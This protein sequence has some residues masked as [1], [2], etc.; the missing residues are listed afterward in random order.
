MGV[1]LSIIV[2]ATTSLAIIGTAGR[3]EDAARL[4]GN[5]EM[6]VDR[7]LA[8]ARKVA[9]L[10]KASHLVSGG[11]AWA[12]H[13]AVLLFLADPARFTLQI[14]APAPMV[15]SHDG[16]LE[17]RDTGERGK[18]SFI[19]NPGGTC[20]HYHRQF[21]D[22]LGAT[23]PNWSPFLDFALIAGHPRVTVRVTHGFDARN[24]LVA[25]ADNALAMTFGAGATL[26]DGGTTRTMRSFLR[27]DGRGAAYHLDLSAMK[28]H[29]NA[30]VVGS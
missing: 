22:A 26:K 12:D 24:E 11:A 21:L 9:D 4:A 8:A 3:G 18:R 5:P 20:N 16:G 1:L 15:V 29:P 6:F 14:E 27:R 7:M 19:A 17:Y 30:R 13:I 2:P 10:T 28:L 25:Q 23:R